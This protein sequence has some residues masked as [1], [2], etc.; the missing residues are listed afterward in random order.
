MAEV[1]ERRAG[2]QKK[3]KR[4]MDPS[5]IV[6][7]R[8]RA[9]ILGFVRIWE[10]LVVSGDAFLSWSFEVVSVLVVLP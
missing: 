1:V 9:R 10:R 6:E 8:P 5:K 7:A 4:Y 2:V 3:T